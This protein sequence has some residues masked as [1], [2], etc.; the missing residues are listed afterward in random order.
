[1]C[2]SP[3]VSFREAS[4]APCAASASASAAEI[5]S[6]ACC[7]ISALSAAAVWTVRSAAL[8]KE[9][10]FMVK[11]STYGLGFTLTLTLNP[12]LKTSCAP[13][14]FDFELPILKL[15]KLIIGKTRNPPAAPPLLSHPQRIGQ[16]A[17]WPC[18]RSVTTSSQRCA[19]MSQFVM[20]L[21]LTRY[22]HV[23]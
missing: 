7:A 21:T 19:W 1:M 23:Y 22:K 13:K 15:T 4:A 10:G 16:Y 9:S 12:W 5:K 8:N 17:Q 2:T 14:G 11:G 18:T 6:A 3:P 20:G